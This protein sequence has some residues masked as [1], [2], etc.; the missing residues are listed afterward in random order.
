MWLGT[1]SSKWQVSA[2]LF[3]PLL[4]LVVP[5]TTSAKHK[6]KTQSG[7]KCLLRKLLPGR[8]WRSVPLTPE[9]KS[10]IKERQNL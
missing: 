4:V 3:M 2:K 7:Q 5:N 10:A 8:H 9:L 6:C 1:K